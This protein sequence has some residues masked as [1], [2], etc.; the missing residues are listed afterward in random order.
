[1]TLNESIRLMHRL[2]ESAGARSTVNF[3]DQQGEVAEDIGSWPAVKQGNTRP[4]A[5]NRA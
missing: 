3:L 4:N 1:M 5:A 2:N